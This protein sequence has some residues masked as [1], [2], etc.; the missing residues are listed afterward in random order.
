M[1]KPTMSIAAKSRNQSGSGLQLPLEILLTCRKV[2]AEQQNI[3]N[4]NL[5]HERLLPH[6]SVQDVMLLSR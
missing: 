2:S 1:R 6:Q 4:N 5:K 3:I